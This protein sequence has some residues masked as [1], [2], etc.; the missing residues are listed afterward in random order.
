M[1]GNYTHEAS[2][3]GIILTAAIYNRDNQNHRDNFTP[4][5]LGGYSASLTQMQQATDPGGVGTE[6][7]ATD[8]SG[9]LA[10]LRYAL[11]RL[12]GMSKWYEAPANAASIGGNQS[13]TAEDFGYIKNLKRITAS[14]NLTIPAASTVS[15]TK[16]L[17]IK[18]TVDFLVNLQRSGS[19]TLDGLTAYRL[20]PYATVELISNGTN[21]YHLIA[22]PYRRPGH[23]TLTDAAN[24][25]WNH[26]TQPQAQ[27]TLA[28]NRT[29]DNPTDTADGTSHTLTVIQDGVGTRTLAYGS[30][31][32]WPLNT[33]PILSTAA[34][35]KDILSFITIGGLH[36][37]V[38]AFKFA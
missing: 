16:R 12:T 28:G 38:A 22:N 15:A 1:P 7:L 30:N 13:I 5:G 20:P 24:I 37:G 26:H 19:D 32:R 35:S 2:Q 33:A 25:S 14:A 34:G 27:V 17:T 11:N 36:Y 3:D 8:G 21:G 18:N 4:D 6:S 31:Y 29:L 9:E 10:R 23:D